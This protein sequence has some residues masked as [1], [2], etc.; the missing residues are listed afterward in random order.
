VKAQVGLLATVRRCFETLNDLIQRQQVLARDGTAKRNKRPKGRAA[1]EAPIER[2]ILY[3]D[4]L[5]RCSAEQVVQV[6]E[7]LH[8]LLAFPCFVVV[9]AIDARWLRRSLV[10]R[11]EQ[12]KT[13]S[14][15]EEDD[16]GRPSPTDYLEK[17]FQIPFWV[18]PLTVSRGGGA[19]ASVYR[20]YLDTLLGP[21]ELKEASTTTVADI[22]AD[23]GVRNE[24]FLPVE[25]SKPKIEARPRAERVLLS[26][27]ERA[28]L[29]KLEP[30]A[31][32]SPRAVKRLVNIYRLI[33]ASVPQ[34]DVPAF[35]GSG[36]KAIP[37]Y[38]SVLFVL[39]LDAGLPAET[40]F[41]IQDCL[42]KLSPQSWLALADDPGSLFHTAAFDD[43]EPI[44]DQHVQR[45]VATL[46]RIEATDGFVAA[47]NAA[48]EARNASL[49]RL[50]LLAAFALTQRYS[51]RAG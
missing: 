37:S 33:K 38:S 23:E 12:F 18:R 39:A 35:E 46:A 27:G 30:I 43:K 2:I 13:D 51:F 48:R 40:T 21:S 36:S 1:D 25:P 31:A 26:D 6:L 14:W 17:I 22:G 41:V 29:A 47:L 7:A 42:E 3:I 8:L 32:K 16:Y 10:L 4:D 34:A 49:D 50:E 9:V 45:L 28:L 11:H 19:E 44:A 20:A 24:A 15:G 5:D